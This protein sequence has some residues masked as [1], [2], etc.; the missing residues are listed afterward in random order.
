MARLKRG[1]NMGIDALILLAGVTLAL[2]IVVLIVLA[3]TS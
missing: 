2:F 3:L 1:H